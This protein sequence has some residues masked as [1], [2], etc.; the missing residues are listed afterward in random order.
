MFEGRAPALLDSWDQA[1]ITAP[2]FV[3]LEVLFFL[4]YRK[5]FHQD[6]MKEVQLEMDKFKASKTK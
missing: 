2:L 5:R 4:G 3:I 6:C 1:F